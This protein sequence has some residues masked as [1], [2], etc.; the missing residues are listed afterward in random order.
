MVGI[1]GLPLGSGPYVLRSDGESTLTY[2]RGLSAFCAGDS[3]GSTGLHVGASCLG[4]VLIIGIFAINSSSL[5][6]SSRKADR[7]EDPPPGLS[8]VR[9]TRE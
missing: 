5:G 4:I 1:A 9:L 7:S 2:V 6:R 8:T 3:M